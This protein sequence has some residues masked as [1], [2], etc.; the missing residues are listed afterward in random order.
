MTHVSI[1]NFSESIL[2]TIS[3][4]KRLSVFLC[5]LI[6]DF[7]WNISDMFSWQNESK[8]CT[9][10]FRLH[11]ATKCSQTIMYFVRSI[12]IFCLNRLLAP[13]NHKCHPFF[14]ATAFMSSGIV[15]LMDMDISLK[16]VNIS[17]RLW[18][19]TVRSSWKGL[20][21]TQKYWRMEE[22]NTTIIMSVKTLLAD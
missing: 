1:K 4:R 17:P 14:F 2:Q 3:Q 5:R 11:F 10:F 6:G 15:S 9:E 19:K 12:C 16:G 20:R 18:V 7:V 8:K 22:K 13:A 21:R